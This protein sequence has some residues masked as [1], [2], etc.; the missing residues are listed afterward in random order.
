MIDDIR[1]IARVIHLLFALALSSVVYALTWYTL[2]GTMMEQ[3]WRYAASCSSALA[4]GVLL[5]AFLDWCVG[6][7]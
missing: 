2:Q 3:R 6:V 7:P 5:H 1:P 4:A